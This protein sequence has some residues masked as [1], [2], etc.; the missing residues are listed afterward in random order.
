MSDDLWFAVPK[1]LPGPTVDDYMEHVN[2][3]IMSALQLPKNLIGMATLGDFIAICA[4]SN[5][6]IVSHGDFR[7]GINIADVLPSEKLVL[8]EKLRDVVSVGV[9]VVW[10]TCDHEDCAELQEMAT[11]CALDRHDRLRKEREAEFAE[12]TESAKRQRTKEGT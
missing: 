6:K 11:A 2:R 8:V 4:M 10:T 9:T 12:R 5:A 7:I 3:S 1:D